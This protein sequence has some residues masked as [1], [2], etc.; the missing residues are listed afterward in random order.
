MRIIDVRG[1]MHPQGGQTVEYLAHDI[2]DANDTKYYGFVSHL[3]SWIIMKQVTSAGTL[4]FTAGKQDYPTNY[5]GR[6]GLSYD[7]LNNI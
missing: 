1:F 7:Y 3:G 2:D 5:T 4:R 6:A